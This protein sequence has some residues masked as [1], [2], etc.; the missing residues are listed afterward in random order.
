MP[1]SSARIWKLNSSLMSKNRA[2][3]FGLWGGWH[4]IC[5]MLRESLYLE[6]SLNS[7]PAPHTVSSSLEEKRIESPGRPSPRLYL[8]LVAG[9]NYGWG[10][11][12]RYLIQELSRIIDCRVLNEEDA[13]CRNA[14]LDGK[15]FQALTGVDFF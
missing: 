3:G 10:V 11:C 12:S 9:K 5:K 15:L 7:M 8:G 14:D 4:W 13:G 6:R 1:S 2:L